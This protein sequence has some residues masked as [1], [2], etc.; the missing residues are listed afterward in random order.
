MRV[1]AGVARSLPLKTVPGLDTRPTID[2]IKETLFNILQ[3]DIAGSKF[4]D[5][6]SGSGGI[7]IEALSRGA[8]KC[9][10]VEN[11]KAACQCIK[12]N[13]TFTKLSDNAVVMEMDVLSAINR[14]KSKD[15]FDIV[16]MD[17]PYNH[18]Y[19]RDVLLSLKESGIIDGYSII[20]A[21]ESLDADFS[22]VSDYGY[23]IYKFKNYKT[24]KHVF[25]RLKGSEE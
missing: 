15:V 24:N 17:P 23:E 9:V 6:Y 21:E 10:F 11:S 18:D 22:Y 5:L 14:L 7:G 1:I 8:G 19:S 16:Y 3:G 12:D 13:L 25:M 2:K 4:L 20:I